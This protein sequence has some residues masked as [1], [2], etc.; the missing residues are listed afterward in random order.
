MKTLKGCTKNLETEQSPL[1]FEKITGFMASLFY[2]N[3][4]V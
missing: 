3:P 4:A 2:T 1:R